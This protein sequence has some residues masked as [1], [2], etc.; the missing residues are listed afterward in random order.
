MKQENQ[1]QKSSIFEIYIFSNIVWNSWY[2]AITMNWAIIGVRSLNCSLV[3]TILHNIPTFSA[4]WMQFFF[5]KPWKI[6]EYYFS[7]IS[8]SKKLPKSKFFVA[9]F[10]IT[11][12][13]GK[14]LRTHLHLS[15]TFD[16]YTQYTDRQRFCRRKQHNSTKIVWFALNK[17][18]HLVIKLAWIA[19]HTKQTQRWPI[20]QTKLFH[21]DGR[22]A[23]A[24]RQVLFWITFEFV[25]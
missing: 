2:M 5:P 25:E 22:N 19:K 17:L 4:H 14:S 16:I 8:N 23:L 9:F 15:H 6:F 10:K 12:I 11:T 13:G 1:Q 3:Y 18:I 21:L 7:Q 20:Q 24:A